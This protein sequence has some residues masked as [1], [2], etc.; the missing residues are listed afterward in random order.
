VKTT[1]AIA[2][3]S[4]GLFGFCI[5]PVHA[6]A[7]TEAASFLDIPVGGR[8]AA[9]GDAYAA[10]ADD[11]YAMTSNPGG[12]GFVNTTELAGQHLSYL[13]SIHYEYM[14]LVHPIH[15]GSTVGI[16]AQYLGSGDI[17]QTDT[18]G[19]TVGQYSTHFA[20]YSIAYGQRLGE[21]LGIGATA[22]VIDAAIAGVSARAW[23]GD[24]GA[25]YK[26]TDKLRLSVG[27]T[28]MGTKLTFLSDGGT[29]PLA[30]KVGAAYQ[31]FNSL[32][33]SLQGDYPKTGL[34][35]GHL[36]VEWKPIEMIA[37]RAGYRTDTTKGLDAMAG[38]TTGLGINVWGQELAYAWV[39]YGDLGNTQYFSFLA[40]FGG[41]AAAARRNLIQ[42][43]T[44]KRS[45]SKDVKMVPSDPDYQQLMQL[46]S[47]QDQEFFTKRPEHSGDLQ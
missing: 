2:V 11:A 33:I 45:G 21:R 34:A 24:I 44:M 29:L 27:G 10:L 5:P 8:P 20:A 42:Y 30:A 47:D 14:S 3:I 43:Q 41:D 32:L 6:G 1:G 46:L 28:N 39:P 19:M 35:S 7:G 22:K 9:L 15:Q 4:I 37:L 18:T 26:A 38:L 17:T 23:A 25:L 12:L 16:S 13:E 36:G 31:L 40:R